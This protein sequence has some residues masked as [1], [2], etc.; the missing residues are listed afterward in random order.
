MDLPREQIE[1][2]EMMRTI[3]RGINIGKIFGFDLIFGKFFQALSI[4]CYKIITYI[5]NALLRTN[6]Y[7]WKVAQIVMILKLGEKLE[8]GT[9]YK[10]I[11]LLPML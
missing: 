2:K 7:S 8:D 5:F 10:L 4:K 1:I 9:F 6:Y 11:G 3:I